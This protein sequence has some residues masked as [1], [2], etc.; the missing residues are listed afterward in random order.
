[1]E[2][3]AYLQSATTYEDPGPEPALHLPAGYLPSAVQVG[4]AAGAIAFSVT[5]FTPTAQAVVRLGDTCPEVLDIQNALIQR[6]YLTGAATGTFD[7]NTRQAVLQLQT[8]FRLNATGEV[9]NQTATVLELNN[10]SDPNGVFG[11]NQSC[12]DTSGGNN[13]GGNN[14]G[15][16]DPGTTTSAKVIAQIGVNVR[17]QPTVS[18]P[19]IGTRSFGETVVIN[20]RRVRADGYTWAQLADQSGWLVT[21]ALSIGG[22]SGGGGS[23]TSAVVI[24]GI[25]VN[26]RSGPGLSHRVIGTRSFGQTVRIN[27]QRVRA[28]GY[29]WAQLADQSGWLVT[30]ALSIGDSG[31]NGGGGGVTS[32]RV[33]A[34]IGANV[35]IAPGF[36]RI[37]GGKAFGQTVLLTSERVPAS[38]YTWA[39]LADQPGWM[40]TSTLSIGSGGG[41]GTAGRVIVSTN[42]SGLNARVGPGLGYAI[43]TA[44]PDGTV[45]FTTGRASNGWIELTNGLW[46]S[47]TW[48]V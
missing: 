26:V 28:N 32:A 39:K 12:T 15:G 14:G 36:T 27:D 11:P 23:V 18:S 8:D 21:A 48:V 33:I 19:R 9:D 38:G 46:V 35:R 7:E 2:T 17:S 16:G 3:L 10:A 30:S 42:G 22:G 34:S 43:A 20:D 44:Y 6:G 24:A 37:I 31:G 5:A 41:G 47:S 13:G 29:T 25:G 4:A 1:M 45:L 40:A